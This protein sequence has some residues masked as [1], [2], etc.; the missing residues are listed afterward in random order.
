MNKRREYRGRNSN[1]KSKLKNIFSQKKN[2][3]AINPK[4]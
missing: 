3:L 4:K 1:N 2:K